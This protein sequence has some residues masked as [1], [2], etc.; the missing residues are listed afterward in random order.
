MDMARSC[1]RGGDDEAREV[2]FMTSEARSAWSSTRISP[3]SVVGTR[4]HRFLSHRFFSLLLFL[5]GVSF[6]VPVLSASFEGCWLVESTEVDGG[7]GVR[8]TEGFPT[9]VLLR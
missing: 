1:G 3:T 2:T 6:L 8:E 4:D 5:G 9:P 7:K